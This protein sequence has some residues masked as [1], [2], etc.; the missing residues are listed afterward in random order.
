MMTH[1]DRDE[2]LSKLGL[3]TKQTGGEALVSA[4]FPFGM[5][6]L[7][8]AGVALLLA[9]GSGRSLR[10]AIGELFEANGRAEPED[11]QHG[12]GGFEP[13]PKAKPDPA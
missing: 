1:L 2:L 5:G 8:G 12:D 4:I 6:L 9:P 13:E 7:L 3:Q 11:D 10:Q